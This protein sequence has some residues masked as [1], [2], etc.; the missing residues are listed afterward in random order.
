MRIALIAEVFLP[1]V[2]GVVNRTLH[3]VRQLLAAGDEVLVICPDAPGCGAVPVDVAHAELFVS[4]LSGIS[5]RP[6]RRAGRRA[7]RSSTLMSSIM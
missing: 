6:A 2:D 1:K 3:L 5:D 7:S 4:A